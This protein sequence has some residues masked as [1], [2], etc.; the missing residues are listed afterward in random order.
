MDKGGAYSALLISSYLTKTFLPTNDK[1][2]DGLVNIRRLKDPPEV[3]TIGSAHKR[4]CR[5]FQGQGLNFLN[6]CFV[7]CSSKTFL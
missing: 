6:F 2:F 3:L 5:L 7:S 1:V 4:G